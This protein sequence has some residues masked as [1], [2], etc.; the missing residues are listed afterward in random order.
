MKKTP[1]PP[2]VNTM[3]FNA[4]ATSTMKTNVV[5]KSSNIKSRQSHE[6]YLKMIEAAEFN[7]RANI[8][9]DIVVSRFLSYKRQ[10]LRL[11]DYDEEEIDDI[12][13][14]MLNNENDEYY[15]YSSDEDDHSVYSDEETF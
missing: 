3:N 15:D 10:E 12:I 1:S 6:E 2:T 5:A 14:K 11:E 7:K 13:E 8:Q 4:N 9:M